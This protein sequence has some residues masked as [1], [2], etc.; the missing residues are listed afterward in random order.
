MTLCAP[1]A[2]SDRYITGR[3]LP[4]KAVDLLD[5]ASARV[6]IGLGIKPAELER[7]ERQLSRLARELS[8]LERDRGNGFPV[9]DQR[10][11]DIADEQAD[12]DARRGALEVRW[13]A[14]GATR[15]C[16]CLKR[17]QLTLQAQDLPVPVEGEVDQVLAS[18]RNAGAS[19]DQ[20]PRSLGRAARRCAVA[21]HQ[22][23]APGCDCPGGFRLDR[24]AAGQVLRP[25]RAAYWP[26][27]TTCQ[28]AYSRSGHRR[29]T[30]RGNPQAAQ[31]GLRDPQQ[32][33]GVFLL[34]RAIGGRQGRSHGRTF[35]RRR[36]RR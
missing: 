19:L 35:V 33:L 1:P 24:C 31:S 15:R 20:G 32:P 30:D 9:E 17:K 3:L 26:W 7:M 11:I 14:E 22:K 28:A 23:M 6:R 25:R 2:V 5:T 16:V 34:V 4:D 8:A 13:L 10:L 21:V 12:I 27:P 36:R 18:W 29:R